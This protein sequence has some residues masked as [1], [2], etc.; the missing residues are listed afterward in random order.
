MMLAHGV[1]LS[2][3]YD[4]LLFAVRVAEGR[5]GG[6]A[7]RAVATEYLLPHAHD[8]VGRFLQSFAFRVFAYG[9]EQGTHGIAHLCFRDAVLQFQWGVFLLC[10]R[11]FSILWVWSESFH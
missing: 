7:F 4:H 8:A 2:A 3:I 9:Q 6:F 1:V 5:D 11:T 10:H